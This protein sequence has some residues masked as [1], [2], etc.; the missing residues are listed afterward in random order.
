[1]K[2]EMIFFAAAMSIFTI[3]CSGKRPSNI[4]L[5]KG[6]LAE[7]PGSPNCV[8]SQSK[9]KAHYIDP[10]VYQGSREEAVDK[11]LSVI[12][13]EKRTNIIVQEKDYIH[14]EFTSLIFRFVDDVEFY[15]N[16]EKKIIHIR[17]AS[18]L[19]YSDMG[20]NR[21]RIEGIREK[22]NKKKDLAEK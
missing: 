6:M 15:F 14:A 12:K 20:A 1:M 16:D 17:S 11:I 9:D 8:S 22:F 7:C 18:R 19:G 10:I 13:S 3:C 4:G 5:N 2:I 21:K